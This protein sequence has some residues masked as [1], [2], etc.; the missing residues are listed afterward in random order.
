[1]FF[2]LTLRLSLLIFL[3]FFNLEMFA[4]NLISES[5]NDKIGLSIGF[6]DQKVNL[7]GVDLKVDYSYEIIFAQ[8]N[9]VHPLLEKNLWNLGFIFQSE[10]GITLY[11]LNSNFLTNSK[12]FEFGISGGMILSYK[13]FNENLH[14][15]LLVAA[16][17]H[18]SERSPERQVPGFMFFS[19]YDMGFNFLINKN[20]HLDFRTG[21]RHLSNASL[22][23]PNGGINNWI[24]TLGFLY[25]LDDESENNKNTALTDL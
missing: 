8:F 17:P 23:N 20:L 6:G 12:S 1:M 14:L 13:I 25:Q 16:G 11:K 18:Y 7:I 15:Y 22:Q 5:S 21:F 19:N 10:Y 24:V 4:Q 3:L 2:K 9:Y